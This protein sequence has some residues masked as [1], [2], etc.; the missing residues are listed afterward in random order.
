MNLPRLFAKAVLG[1]L[2]VLVLPAAAVT[3]APPA[4]APA[5]PAVRE[6]LLLAADWRFQKGEPAEVSAALAYSAIRDWV[7]P[8]GNAFRAQPFARPAGTPPGESVALTQPGFDD[9]S[10]RKLDLPHDWGVENDFDISLPGE[11]GKLPWWGVAWYRRHVALP[12]ADE[13]RRILLQVDGAMSFAAVWCNGTFVG[14][15]PY[16]YASWQVDLTP[17]VRFGQDNVI[18][19][20]LDNPPD[21]SRWY[22]GGG[23]YRNVWLEKTAA[24]HV[25]QWG[26]RVTTT[27]VSAASA[28][29]NL[30]VEVANETAA[31]AAVRL[32]TE[33]FRLDAQGNHPLGRAEANETQATGVVQP[34]QRALLKQVMALKRP[35]LW[36]PDKPARY[37]AIT[38]VSVDGKTV[39][40][41]ETR[42]GIR[43]AEF[44]ADDGF[45]LNGKRLPLQG[46]CLHHDLGALGAA[47]H[48]EGA[49]RQLVA[50]KEMGANAIRTSHNPPAPEFLELC[51]RLGFI[52]LDELADTWT[53]PKKPNGY[54]LLFKEWGEADL[55]A[56]I[57]RDRNH[58]SIVAWSIGNEVGEQRNPALQP[59]ASRLSAIAHEE[60][61]TRPSTAGCDFPGS[62]YN[63]FE[64]TID[65]FGYNYKPWEYAKFHQSNPGQPLYGSETASTVSSRGEYVFPVSEDKDQGKIGFQVSS[66]DL[67]APRWA[68]PP[69]REF[70]GQDENPFVAGEFVWTGFDYLGEPTPYNTDLT[71]LTNYHTPEARA[72]AEQEL[73]ALGKVRSPA[74]SSYFGILDLAGFP[75]D[76]FY[77]YQARWRPSL[78]MAHLLPH[79]TW[80][81]RE[82]QVTPVHVYTSGDEAELFLN[83]VSL[84]RRKLGTLQYRLRWDE[85]KYAPGELKVVAYKNGKP[86]ATDTVQTAGPAAKLVLSLDRRGYHGGQALTFVQVMVADAQGRLVP[87]AQTPLKFE[88]TGAGAIVATD[89]GDA[90]DLVGFGSHERK[91]FHGRALVILRKT[92][93]KNEPMFLKVT[94]PGLK[95]GEFRVGGPQS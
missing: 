15:W 68:M 1:C 87:T 11:S 16:G 84:G 69:D 41:Y 44:T 83:G 66:Y 48:L 33:V 77:L 89:N 12:A 32:E 72:K 3:A 54:A 74:R 52:V 26:T 17:Y 42:F 67:Y 88:V 23:L 6:R 61:G 58:P 92:G 56:M 79:W 86:W 78:P 81:G 31:A 9:S 39:D 8:T 82:G 46:V 40:R 55:R 60:D 53:V 13:G 38:R 90:T 76:R 91:A 75:K 7:I 4:T 37:V 25:A 19:V 18:A 73:A 20:R 71:V 85:V 62:G 34:G 70:Q 28:T 45:H 57:R 21:S 14:G 50:L 94:A 30:E 65:V 2:A 51:D 24:V 47:F 29:V 80:P 63:G 10:W 95:P 22:P 36:S 27:E 5:A 93:R 43:T 64:K 49:E 35:A 59:V